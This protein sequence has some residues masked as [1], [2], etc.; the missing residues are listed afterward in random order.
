MVRY[1]KCKKCRYR[2][3]KSAENGCDYYLITGKRRGC[4]IE[5]CQRHLEE[6]EKIQL[7]TKMKAE[8]VPGWLRGT[9]KGN[10]R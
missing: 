10:R 2:A 1:E 9:Y 4:S 6:G 8:V 7:K 5:E 3:A